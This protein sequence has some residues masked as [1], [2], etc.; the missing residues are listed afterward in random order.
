M[1]FWLDFRLQHSMQHHKLSTGEH[2]ANQLQLRWNMRACTHACTHAHTHKG[3]TAPTLSCAHTCVGDCA[4]SPTL[5]DKSDYKQ[6]CVAFM[7][8]Q[9]SRMMT[10]WC[11]QFFRTISPETSKG[12]ALIAFVQHFHWKR[13]VMSTSSDEWAFH[14]GLGLTSQLETA[15]IKVF[16]LPAFEPRSFKAATLTSTLLKSNY[17]IVVFMADPPETAAVS[18]FAAKQ[19]M[20]SGWAWV[21]PHLNHPYRDQRGL[22]R[23]LGRQMQ[24]WI[25]LRPLL[26]SHGMQA[27]AGQVS[28]YTK[29]RFN[30]TISA[31][32]VDLTYS[33]ALYDAIMLYAHAATKVLSEGGDLY[34]SQAV[35]AAMMNTTF[36]GVGGRTV[37]L[38][39]H[40]DRIESYEV[41]NYVLKEGNVM[42]SVA[43]GMFSAGQKYEAYERA[44]VWPGIVL[45]V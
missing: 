22:Y 13:V 17:R 20:A 19:G 37:A 31:D 35:T 14:S 38:D 21:H 34:N 16:K 10:C 36:E 33:T 12:P 44:V 45:S 41:M 24:G 15:G 28:S 5:S 26:P 39:S 18:E 1:T 8:L 11:V 27:F 2:S 42:S 30:I 6:V 25:Y 3:T 40:G 9:F 23:H 29:S 43:V 32:S 4:G 7:R